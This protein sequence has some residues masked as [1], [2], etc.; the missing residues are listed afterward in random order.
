MIRSDFALE[1]ALRWQNGIS[2]YGRG[3]AVGRKAEEPEAVEAIY[4]KEN[5]IRDLRITG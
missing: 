4:M 5:E 2:E 1:I 3:V